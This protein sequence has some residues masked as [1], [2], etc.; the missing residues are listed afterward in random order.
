MKLK[1]GLPKK[2]ISFTQISD[3]INCPK[4]YYLKY[5]ENKR[6]TE[7]AA[8]NYGSMLHESVKLIN[9]SIMKSKED[10]SFEDVE[11]I[12]DNEFKKY[13]LDADSYNRGKESVRAYA[14]KT[15]SEK[16]IILKCEY[17]IRHE[18]PG[19]AVIVG[20]IDRIDIPESDAIEIIDFKAT[21]LIP[22][23]E[24]M[25]RD[26]Q[27]KIYGFVILQEQPEVKKMY[28]SRQSLATE[29]DDEGNVKGG[30]KKKIEADIT[31]LQD[32][33]GY[34]QMIWDKMQ[35]EKEW[36]PNP[37]IS[38]ACRYCPEHC[39]AYKKLLKESDVDVDPDDIIAVGKQYIALNFKLTAINAQYKT[40]K[41]VIKQNFETNLMQ[42]IEIGEKIIYAS[43]VHKKAELNPRPASDYTE[44]SIANN[45][46]VSKNKISKIVS[47]ITKGVVNGKSRIH[48][49]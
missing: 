33:G 8:L 36:R 27:L 34:L 9:E 30:F 28:L 18:L 19:G 13:H 17:E 16:S 12:F 5:F 11:K 20:R 14:L 15:I 42:E 39:E 29:I 10:L 4:C 43:Q 7:S 3:Y 40:L 44:I 49:K 24:T 1:T 35:A 22:S 6:A 46:K 47:K 41:K 25:K 21:P 38:G 32:V 45:V 37:D 31:Q 48:R 26:L 2:W 23:T